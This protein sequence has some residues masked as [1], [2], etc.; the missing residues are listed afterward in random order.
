MKKKVAAV[1]DQPAV[2]KSQQRIDI[3]SRLCIYDTP[4][5]L[6]LKIEHEADGLKLAASHAVGI[7]AYIDEEVATWFAGFLPDHYSV[8]GVRYGFDPA[9]FDAAG[10]F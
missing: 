10:S 1:G 4:G 6:G 5:L 3:S 9:A 8:A 7:N 2:T